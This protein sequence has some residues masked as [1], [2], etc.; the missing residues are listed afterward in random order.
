MSHIYLTAD[1]VRL[2]IKSFILCNQNKTRIDL[3]F[4]RHLGQKV[5]RRLEG[6]CIYSIEFFAFSPPIWIT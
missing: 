2:I 6:Q 3:R 5:A 4:S 1:R